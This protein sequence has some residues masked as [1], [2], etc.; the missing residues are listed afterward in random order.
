VKREGKG[1]KTNALAPQ[2][3][4]AFVIGEKKGGVIFSQGQTEKGKNGG[5]KIRLWSWGD[6]LCTWGEKF[7]SWGRRKRKKEGRYFVEGGEKARPGGE[8]GWLR[9]NRKKHRLGGQKKRAAVQ[10]ERA[11]PAEKTNTILKKR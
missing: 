6:S 4:I 3:V 11:L 7:S 10:K 2:K 5:K 1:A 9:R 8:K